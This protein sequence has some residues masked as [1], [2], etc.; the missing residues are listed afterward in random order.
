MLSPTRIVINETMQEY[1]NHLQFK[2][3]DILE[4]GIDGDESPSGSYRYFGNGNNWSTMDF[5]KKVNP[6]YVVDLTGDELPDRKWDLVIC[7]QT[8]EHIYYVHK[9]V[10]NISKM[11]KRGG[12]VILDN[13]WMSPYHT[14]PEYNDYWRMTLPCM[15]AMCND[16][17]IEIIDGQ[18][19][20]HYVSILG[21]KI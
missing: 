15:A 19:H 1:A 18:Q 14:Q 21:R 10:E 7:L 13:P 2:Q 6:D 4:I 5:L 20:E 12:Y 16:V 8:L 11:V 9:A 17:G 3:K